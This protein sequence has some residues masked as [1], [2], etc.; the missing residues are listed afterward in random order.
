MP[1]EDSRCARGGASGGRGQG[2]PL[3]LPGPASIGARP[4]AH[5]SPA[6]QPTGA[7]AHCMGSSVSKPAKLTGLHSRVRRL[8]STR[9]RVVPKSGRVRTTREWWRESGGE[10]SLVCLMCVCGGEQ[11]W[12]GLAGVVLACPRSAQVRSVVPLYGLARCYA[13]GAALTWQRD[14]AHALAVVALDKGLRKGGLV[15]GKVDVRAL[16]VGI[17]VG[18]RGGVRVRVRIGLRVG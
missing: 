15:G 4:R 3:P 6:L 7:W 8:T 16:L 10:G 11:V 2:G 1:S 14:D 5:P 17:T 13:H 18:L 9:V 12:L